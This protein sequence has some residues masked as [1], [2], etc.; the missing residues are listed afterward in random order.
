M[1]LTSAVVAVQVE[2]QEGMGMAPDKYREVFDLALRGTRAFRDRRFD[3]VRLELVP[4]L[5]SVCV[6]GGV[7]VFRAG[8]CS[9][10][11]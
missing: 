3:E 7:S 9:R 4:F 6:R 11:A 1:L 5:Q 2:G 10:L 8:V